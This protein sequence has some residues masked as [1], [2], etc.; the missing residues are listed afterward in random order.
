MRRVFIVY[1]FVYSF[2]IQSLF[3]LYSSCIHP[4]FDP[5]FIYHRLL[6]V[7]SSS[8]HLLFICI[9]PVFRTMSR[10]HFALYSC[11]YSGLPLLTVL[12]DSE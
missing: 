7:Y 10:H 8:I 4:L 1:S 11:Q 9:E 3:I 6:I 5:G 12:I 2:S